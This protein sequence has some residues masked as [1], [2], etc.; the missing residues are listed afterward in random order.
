[1]TNHQIWRPYAQMH[2]LQ[3]PLKVEKAEGCLLHLGDGRILIDGASSWWSAIHG[4]SNPYIVGKMQE[5]LAKFSHVMFAGLTHE[6]AEILADRLIKILPQGLQHIFFS[7]SGSTAVEVSLKMAIQYWRNLGKNKKNKFVSF[8][9]GYHGDTLGAMAVSDHDGWVHKSYQGYLPMHLQ[10]DLPTDEYQLA[11]FAALLESLHK[12]IA[13]IIIEPLVQCAGG[14]KFYGAD[15]L[16]EIARLAKEYEIL[17]IA[18]EV[19]TGFGRTGMM[20]AC[21]EAGIS[22]DIMCLGKAISAGMLTFAAT[23][24]NDE[25]YNAFLGDDISLALMHGPTYMGNALACSAANASLDLFE[26]QPILQ[27]V[28]EIEN[29]LHQGLMAAREIKGVRDVRVKGSFGVV[30]FNEGAFEIASLRQKFPE[31]GVWLRPFA[32]II[33][34]APPYV[35]EKEQLNFLIKAVIEV[36]HEG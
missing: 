26:R 10:V 1:M 8:K 36:L 34:I 28:A 29:L 17:L 32:D 22:P 27:K 35:I 31:K 14:M 16:A 13:A 23:A 24:A 5:Q 19:A 21:E 12:Q 15:I 30:Q 20:F 18:D 2:N 7:D 33:Y 3:A 6:P 9:N 11:E 4:Y 25:V